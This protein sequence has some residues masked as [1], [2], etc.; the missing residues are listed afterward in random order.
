MIHFANWARN[1]RSSAAAWARPKTEA[2]VQACV[3]DA[4]RAGTRVKVVGAAHSWSDIAMSANASTQLLSLDEMGAGSEGII[5]LE[6][7]DEESAHVEVWAGTF[8]WA[9]GPVGSV[10]SPG[11]ARKKALFIRGTTPNE[12]VHF[13]FS[14]HCVSSNLCF[15]IRFIFMLSSFRR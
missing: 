4:L 6:Q 5:E 11:L 13:R 2:E 9:V 8:Q 10:C 15:S 7:I 12:T 3:R 14:W 1:Q